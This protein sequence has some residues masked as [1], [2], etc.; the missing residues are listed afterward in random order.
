MI[1]RFD[2]PSFNSI[3]KLVVHESHFS[4]SVYKGNEELIL[5]LVW[6][7]GKDQKVITDEVE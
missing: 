3:L 4:H 6:N 2:N 1:L 5:S 7:A